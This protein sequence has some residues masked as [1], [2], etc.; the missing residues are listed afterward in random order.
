[1][2]IGNKFTVPEKYNDAI[3]EDV[4]GYQIIVTE[5]GVLIQGIQLV[6]LYDL[7]IG[8]V[9]IIPLDKEAQETIENFP[10]DIEN[11]CL[12]FQVTYCGLAWYFLQKEYALKLIQIILNVKEQA[13]QVKLLLN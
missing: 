4:G 2:K 12:I 11:N 3:I 6:N 8:I 1:M 5:E 7:E 10:F 13:L 9:G